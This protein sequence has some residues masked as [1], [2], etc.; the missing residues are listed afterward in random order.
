M[1]ERTIV[2]INAPWSEEVALIVMSSN[3]AVSLLEILDPDWFFHCFLFAS[4]KQSHTLGSV[5]VKFS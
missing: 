4:R 2:R 1:Q 5:S 3:S